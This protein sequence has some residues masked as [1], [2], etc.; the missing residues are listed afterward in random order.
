MLHTFLTGFDQTDHRDGNGLNCQR[1][2]LRR[3]TDRQNR[4]GR[5]AK[6][7]NASSKFRGVSWH[8]GRHKWN[9]AIINNGKYIWLGSY[10]DERLAAKV[11]DE[12]AKK[13][14]GEFAAPNFSN[15]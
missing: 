15:P 4:Q 7:K 9:A 8:S 2:N 11:Y 12:A 13:Y 3:A 14:F 10:D 1:R 5:Q 6:R